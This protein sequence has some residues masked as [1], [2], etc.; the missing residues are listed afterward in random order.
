LPGGSGQ[1]GVLTHAEL[2]QWGTDVGKSLV[3]PTVLALTGDLGAGKTTLVQAIC[4]GV[5]IREDVTSPTFSLVN[6]YEVNGTTVYHLD[7]YRLEGPK[8]LTNLGWDEI[9][10]SGG[11][12]FVEW[13]DRAEGRLPEDALGIRL[14]HLPGD[15]GHRRI[16][17]G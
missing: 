15:S 6:Q 2:V 13:A 5:G 11:L 3:P 17:I 16:V 4:R 8:D 12:V 9:V 7:L 10:N 14:E 1:P